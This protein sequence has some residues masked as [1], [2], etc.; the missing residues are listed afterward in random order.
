MEITDNLF[1]LAVPGA[2][3]AGLV[4]G[5]FWGSLAAS[6]IVAF[7]VTVPINR[8]LIQRGKGHAVVHAYHRH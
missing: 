3:A 4:D 2:L 7:I 5:L 6:L 1:L 8:A